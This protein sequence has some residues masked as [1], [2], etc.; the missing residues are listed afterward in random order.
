M[1]LRVVSGY[2]IMGLALVAN[3]GEVIS[4]VALAANTGEKTILFVTH[5]AAVIAISDRVVE[6]DS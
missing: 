4:R 5:R 6:F 3:M 1:V 2:P